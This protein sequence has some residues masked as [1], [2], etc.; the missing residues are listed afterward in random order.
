[1][2]FIIAGWLIN[3]TI[4][5]YFILTKPEGAFLVIIPC[6][7]GLIGAIMYCIGF[8]RLGL[9]LVFLGSIFFVPAGLIACFGVVKEKDKLDDIIINTNSE[10]K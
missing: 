5:F 1:M 6:A 7:I 9:N 8:K 10:A 3:L 4:S 2:N